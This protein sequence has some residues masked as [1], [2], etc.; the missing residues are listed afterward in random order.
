MLQFHKLLLVAT[1]LK[2]CCLCV[3]AWMDLFPCGL[4]CMYVGRV[5][6]GWG[7]LGVESGVFL[8]SHI[9]QQ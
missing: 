5:R 9:T 4:F 7:V 2:V 8:P 6:K 3:L 1:C